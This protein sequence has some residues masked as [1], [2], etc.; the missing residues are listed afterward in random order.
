MRF[1]HLSDL[2]IGKRV[3]GFSMLEDQRHILQQIADLAILHHLDGILVAGDLYDKTVPP[4]E[5]VGVL[6]TFFT[7]VVQ[8]GIP[9]FAI[10]GN[11]DS[12]ERLG[13][14]S[15]LLEDTGV[16]LAAQ[17]TPGRPPVILKDAYGE[18][19]VYLLPYLRPALVRHFCPGSEA[20]SHQEAVAWA[21]AQ[22]ELD[23][24][25]RNVLLAHQFVVGGITCDSE[26]RSVGGTDRVSGELFS[27]F[28]YVALGHLHGPQAIGRES[29][30]YSGSPLKYSISEW[31]QEKSVTLLTLA[32]KG[33]LTV[34]TLPLEPLRDL[35]EIRGTYE[36]VTARAFYLGRNTEDY[37]HVVLTDP[38][39]IPEAV[40][41]LRAIY[42]NLM[43]L[44]YAGRSSAESIGLP[45]AEYAEARTPLELFQDLYQQQ[46][47][48]PMDPHQAEYLKNLMES[49]WEETP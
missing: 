11:H 7:T 42:P 17:W 21:L 46:N 47:A 3:N 30:R 10:S 18:V 43:K 6:D 5:A 19:A 49:I 13:F 33:S 23:P 45:Q 31:R 25:R 15:T 35:R 36:E 34:E 41:R 1:F 20:V 12:P 29:L 37:L 22:W 38:Q 44:S 26:E 2:H 48:C 24:K 14:G 28:D 27:A 8:A 32:E 9:V 4:A 16:H 39:D 40:G